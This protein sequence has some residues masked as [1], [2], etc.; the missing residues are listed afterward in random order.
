M[1]PYFPAENVTQ[2]PSSKS[3][4][5]LIEIPAKFYVVFIYLPLPMQ[6]HIMFSYVHNIYHL[7]ILPDLFLLYEVRLLI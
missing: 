1:S 6:H 5:F 3:F 7:K 4:L 2:F